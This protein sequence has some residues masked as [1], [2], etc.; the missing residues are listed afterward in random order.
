VSDTIE[1]CKQTTAAIPA[2][3]PGVEVV[4][5]LVPGKDDLGKGRSG[6]ESFS[7]R[8]DHLAQVAPWVKVESPNTEVD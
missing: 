8:K 4:V 2:P 5:L 7:K 1:T 3:A 6:F